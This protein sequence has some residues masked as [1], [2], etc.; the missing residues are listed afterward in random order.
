MRTAMRLDCLAGSMP[1]FEQHTQH[2]S[3]E[4]VSGGCLLAGQHGQAQQA[5]FKP[6]LDPACSFEFGPGESA[7][8]GLVSYDVLGKWAL[9]QRR[10]ASAVPVPA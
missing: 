5:C 2:M 8:L 6:R 9:L 7:W 10:P 3:K 4:G 1:Q